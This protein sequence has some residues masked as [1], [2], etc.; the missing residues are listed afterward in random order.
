M[1]LC[2]NVVEAQNLHDVK[3]TL[4][5][6]FHALVGVFHQQATV[7]FVGENSNKGEKSENYRLL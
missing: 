5:S 3:I 1:A 2:E 7:R 6:P 4:K